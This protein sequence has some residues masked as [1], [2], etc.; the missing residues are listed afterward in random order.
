[1]SS[2]LLSMEKSAGGEIVS[3]LCRFQAKESQAHSLL[4]GEAVGGGYAPIT[5]WRL[6][7]QRMKQVPANE[8]GRKSCPPSPAKQGDSRC[9]GFAWRRSAGSIN[10]HMAPRS[11]KWPHAQGTRPEEQLLPDTATPQIPGGCSVETSPRTPKE[12]REHCSM[13]C[14]RVVDSSALVLFFLPREHN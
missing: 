12:S 3:N 5:L 4:G 11:Q 13:I 10:C 1:M 2:P 6:S 9:G 8:A 7:S 14:L